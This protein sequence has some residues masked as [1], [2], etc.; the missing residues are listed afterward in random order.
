MLA[1]TQALKQADRLESCS[2]DLVDMGLT[3][4]GQIVI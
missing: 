3:F 1:W 4:F 2:G